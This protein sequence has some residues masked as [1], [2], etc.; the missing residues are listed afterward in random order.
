MNYLTDRA[1]YAEI[2]GECS[3]TKH[4]W[5]GALHGSLLG[6]KLYSLHVNDLPSATMQGAIYLLQMIQLFTAQATTWGSVVDTSN[7]IMDEIRVYE[8]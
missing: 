6:H 5:F 4:V 2:N 1:Q 7:S 8:L 3:S